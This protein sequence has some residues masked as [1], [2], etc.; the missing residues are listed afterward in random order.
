MDAPVQSCR[1]TVVNIFIDVLH[2][3]K[4]VGGVGFAHP[5]LFLNLEDK[6]CSLSFCALSSRVCYGWCLVR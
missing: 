2:L 4:R 1:F 3:E 6:V 5:I